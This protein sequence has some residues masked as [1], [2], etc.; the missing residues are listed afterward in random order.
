MKEEEKIPT[1]SLHLPARSSVREDY[2]KELRFPMPGVRNVISGA[3]SGTRI[4]T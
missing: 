4:E 2:L 1:V 3:E